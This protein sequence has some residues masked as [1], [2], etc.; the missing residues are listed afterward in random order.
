M[1]HASDVKPLRRVVRDAEG[2]EYVAEILAREVRLRPVRAKRGGPSEFV[3][4][5]G[6]IYLD[7]AS[8][9]PLAASGGRRPARSRP[10]HRP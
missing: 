6:Q 1:T 10:P 9:G 4:S 5:W 3:R 2:R 8:G 7:A